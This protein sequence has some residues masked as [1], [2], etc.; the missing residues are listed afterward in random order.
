VAFDP[1]PDL[2]L[3]VHWPYCARICP[4]CDFNV[5]RARGREA[6][7]AALADALVRDLETQAEGLGPR[8]LVSVFFGGGTPSLMDPATVGRIVETASRLFAPAPD[9][10]VTLEANPTDAEAERFTAFA[11]A[12]VERL[13]L[14]LQ[15]LDDEALAFLGRNHDSAEGRRAAEAA[16]RAFPRLS[17][18]LIY[19]RPGQTPEAWA[20]ELKDAVALGAGHVS[21]YQLTIEAGTPFGLA[22]SRG[23]FV[24]PDQDL[25]A[26]LYDT[27]QAVLEA[28]GFD[29]YEVSNHARGEAARSRHNLAIWK[30]AEYLGIGP[31]AHGRVR[32]DAIRFATRGAPKIADYLALV[33]QSGSGLDTSDPLS[34]RDA[35]EERALL[36]LRITDGLPLADF[37]ALGL[38]P[39]AEPARSMI[40]AGLLHLTGDAIAATPAGRLVLDRVIA[41]LLTA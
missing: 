29:A 11:D 24:P 16:A 35:A 2:A 27:T 10:E 17:V 6:E 5:A 14:G 41:D 37:T 26:D 22:V 19:A 39:G 28:E 34:P 31:G 33:A 7:A 20:R 13:S 25:A 36:G 1:V 38:S 15:S 32:K 9:L 3:Y 8:R 4:Y 21:P 40:E 23:R 12:G 30:G 18:D